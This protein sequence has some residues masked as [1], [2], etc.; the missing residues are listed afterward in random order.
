MRKINIA[1]LDG[2]YSQR[3][4]TMA[5]IEEYMRHNQ[6]HFKIECF[7]SCASM[8]E[9]INKNGCYDIYFIEPMLKD[10]NGLKAAHIIME[11]NSSSIIV[12]VSKTRTYAYGAFKEGAY[13][14]FETPININRFFDTL[15]SIMKG[16]RNNESL[17]SVEISLKQGF[18][19]I[20][21]D[22]IEYIDIV[23]R[24]ICYHLVDGRTYVGKCIRTQ[25]KAEVGVFAENPWFV[26]AASGCLVNI[27][28]IKLLQKRTAEMTSGAIVTITHAAVEGVYRTWR[29]YNV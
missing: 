15:D 26:F 5:L 18:M 28:H 1:I 20:H 14:Y 2:D 27:E 22:S 9:N 4:D 23:K 11:N 19:R 17:Q 21:I 12:I 13:D 3:K 29:E 8:L 24:A 25:F 16:L 10:S 6:L 7:N